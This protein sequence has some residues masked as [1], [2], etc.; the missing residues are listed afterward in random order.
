MKKKEFSRRN[1]LGTTALGAAGVIGVAG[2]A[3][4]CSEKEIKVSFFPPPKKADDGTPIKAGLIGCGG[5]GTGAAL[6]FLNAGDNLEIVAVADLFEDRI[7]KF[8]ESLKKN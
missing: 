2:L 4:A 3:S 6:N 8:R 7:V 1:F 5:R